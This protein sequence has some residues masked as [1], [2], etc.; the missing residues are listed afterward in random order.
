M[1]PNTRCCPRSHRGCFRAYG[2]FWILKWFWLPGLEELHRSFS[3][4]ATEA[5]LRSESPWPF[6]S[7][8]RMR[9]QSSRSVRATRKPKIINLLLWRK[10]GGLLVALIN[11]RTPSG[12]GLGEILL[13]RAPV[14]TGFQ[15]DR[16]DTHTS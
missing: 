12:P 14:P 2:T 1:W 9:R 15:S 16:N 6:L 8:W 5:S 7:I 13:L 10:K 11:L 4:F 3:S